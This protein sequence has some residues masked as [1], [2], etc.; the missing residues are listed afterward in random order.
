[1]RLTSRSERIE[2]VSEEN[3]HVIMLMLKKKIVKLRVR[4]RA[5]RNEILIIDRSQTTI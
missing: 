5:I 3:A 4:E 2:S 1:M